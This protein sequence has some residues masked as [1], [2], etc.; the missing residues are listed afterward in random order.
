MTLGQRFTIWTATLLLVAVVGLAGWRQ[1]PPRAAIQ[2]SLREPTLPLPPDPA[3][4]FTPGQDRDPILFVVIENTPEARPQAG[5]ADACLV[6]AMA[7]EARITRFMAAHCEA[8]P[9]TIGPIRSARRYMLE[10]AGDVGAILVHS[11]QSNEA[12]DM[13]RT[14]G[15]PVINEFWTSEPF[16][17]EAARRAP[18]NLYADLGLLRQSAREKSVAAV[19]KGLPYRLD[20]ARATTLQRGVA[21]LEVSLGYGPLYDVAYRY[22]AGQRRYLRSQHQKPHLDANG[23]QV[24]AA[25][26]LTMFVPWRDVLVNGQPSSRIDYYGR[27]RLVIAAAGRAVEG[28]WERLGALTLT[29]D[30]GQPLVLP[31]GPVWIELLPAD[32]PF[33]VRGAATPLAA[34]LAPQRRL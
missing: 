9:S 25:S 21:A 1:M 32:S 19:P 7:T 22:D 2:L 12:F 30:Q 15:L 27:G 20:P 8:T 29:D 6:F 14:R 24:S 34:P 4:Q 18:H 10:I 11:G 26:V 17:R 33:D 13:I 31:P 16:R 28:Q 5:L 3:R 23:T